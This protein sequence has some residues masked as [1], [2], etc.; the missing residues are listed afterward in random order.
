MKRLRKE[1]IFPILLRADL[2]HRRTLT[3]V[4]AYNDVDCSVSRLLLPLLEVDEKKALLSVRDE[5][6]WTPL[7]I[8]VAST[9]FKTTA[10]LDLFL[11]D[12][13]TD[14]KLSILKQKTNKGETAVHLAARH[15]T[16]HRVI[17]TLLNERCR[18]SLVGLRNDEG[19]TAIHLAAVHNDNS[20]VIDILLAGLKNSDEIKSMVK[21]CD[22]HQWSP[23]HLAARY[24]GNAVVMGTMLGLLSSSRQMELLCMRT[25]DG[26]SALHLAM[27]YNNCSV[28]EIMTR[29][30][31]Q[32][33]LKSLIYA[34]NNEK[35]TPLEMNEKVTDF[36][37]KIC[38][39]LRMFQTNERMLALKVSNSDL[40]T[41]VHWAASHNMLLI[42]TMLELLNMEQRV[43]ILRMQSKSGK[44]PLDLAIL[45]SSSISQTLG[46]IEIISQLIGEKIAYILMVRDPERDSTIL[47]R[48]MNLMDCPPLIQS[49]IR[50]MSPSATFALLCTVDSQG[51]TPLHVAVTYNNLDAVLAL[52]TPLHDK[53]KA[54]L[55]KYRTKEMQTALHLASQRKNLFRELL[56]AIPNFD[57]HACLSLA[58][59]SGF[60]PVH[61]VARF[62]H[63]F[64][65]VKTMLE[66]LN[67]DDLVE[68]MRQ[69]THEQET[70]LHL[71]AEFMDDPRTI[72]LLLHN[73][74]LLTCLELLS[75]T[76]SQDFTVIHV[77]ALNP[78][79]EVLQEILA[80]FDIDG[81]QNVIQMAENEERLTPIHVAAQHNNNERIIHVLMEPL[82]EEQRTRMLRLPSKK[83]QTPLHLA[84]K[85][86]KNIKVP[87]ALLHYIRRPS[88][89]VDI[90]CITNDDGLTA[91][92]IAGA[93][94]KEPDALLCFM[95]A[96]LCMPGNTQNN[97]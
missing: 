61:V 56:A 89:Q 35:R 12:F 72:S 3:H 33:N 46:V 88:E 45:Y 1:S 4:L 5:H 71:A 23:V 67:P 18:H 93:N 59:C 13:D 38:C 70:T 20:A 22:S 10:L 30:L 31:D 49:F 91:I 36:T 86:N 78:H 63:D 57:K 82:S 14:T 41:P 60:T 85:H 65:T 54:T 51:Y 96:V 69:R 44:T 24:N 37:S 50:A 43:E 53:Q 25:P 48:V 21:M 2:P 73:I 28:I 6:G 16:N 80:K 19:Q 87:Q 74:P 95:K 11:E 17:E 27:Q 81:K 68:S 32:Q 47:H 15:N 64:E 9:V 92:D 75:L 97:S 94:H 58:D 8:H 84:C 66:H 39:L 26:N 42:Q 52:L 83:E 55:L 34:R 40:I 62:C 90:L 29:D 79:E 76:N 7:H 77:A